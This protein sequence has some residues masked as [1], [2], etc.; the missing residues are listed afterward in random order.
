MPIAE[1]AWDAG[2]E[3]QPASADDITATAIAVAM[4]PWRVSPLKNCPSGQETDHS[5]LCAN[6][7]KVLIFRAKGLR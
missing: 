7:P 1:G 2:S 4:Q 6:G 3:L 5:K